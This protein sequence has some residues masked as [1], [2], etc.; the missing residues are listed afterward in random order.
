MW[1]PSTCCFFPVTELT[2]CVGIWY[3]AIFML[4][5]GNWSLGSQYKNGDDLVTAIAMSNKL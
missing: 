4:P 5:C 2:V 1:L 3:V